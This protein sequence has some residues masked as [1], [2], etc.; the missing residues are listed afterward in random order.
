MTTNLT[1][2][3]TVVLYLTVVQR[4]LNQ[5]L[6]ILL[7]IGLLGNMTSCII[8]L[9]KELRHNAV[10][11]LFTAA[12]IFNIIVLT[13]GISYSLYS[14]DNI[15]LDTY[16]IIFCKL[17]LYIRHIFLMTVRSYI[18]LACVACF[19]LSSSRT[20]LRSLCRPQYVKTAIV[21]VPLIWPLIAIHMP[22]LT[23]IRNN[24][25]V[26]I[27]SYV[28][29]FAIYFF[30]IVGIFPI[31]LMVL[32]TL[33]TMNNLR[34]LHHRIQ[35]TIVTPTRLKSRDRQFIRMLSSLVIMYVVTNLFYPTNVLYTAI[36]HW[37]IK[38][39]ERIAIE[40]IITSITS[41]YILY[42]NNISPFFLFVCSSAAYRRVFYRVIYNCVGYL[43][44]ISTLT[45]QNRRE[46]T[47]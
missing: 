29:P 18:I 28:L 9:Q 2:S 1:A 5:N 12:S 26:N 23:I 24:Q 42:I 13:Y 8:F 25:C 40:S 44:M 14:I 16:S 21:V 45:E 3:N 39:L 4:Q 46:R 15:S 7:G 36:T 20:N 6:S 10:S 27:D 31:I 47:I 30:L 35:P 22:I 43:P 17:R 34:R 41:N 33:L 19:A 38:S 32:F 37:S 11:L